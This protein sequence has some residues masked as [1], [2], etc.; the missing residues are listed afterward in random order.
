MITN[1]DNGQAGEIITVIC[2]NADTRFND[3]SGLE[4]AG[5]AQ[6]RCGTNDT[7]QWV[8]DGTNWFNIAGS[9]NS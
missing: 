6:L 4:N 1:F 5:A 9:D 7:F 2:S 3:G 8:Y